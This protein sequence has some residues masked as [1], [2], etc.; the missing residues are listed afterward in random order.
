VF[1][2]MKQGEQV[3]MVPET[4]VQLIACIAE[5]GHFC[6]GATALDGAESL[7]YSEGSGPRLFDRLAHELAE[8]TI[9]ITSASAK[10]LYN[11]LQIGFEGQDLS[12]RLKPLSLLESLRVD[13]NLCSPDELV[14]SRVKIDESAGKCPK[15]GIQLRLINLDA[16]QKRRYREGL[17]HLTIA[18]YEDRYQKKDNSAEH[19]LKSFGQ[20]LENSID[21]PFTAIVDGPNVAFYMQNFQNGGFSY[22]QIQFVVDALEGMGE[23]VLVVLPKKYIHDRFWIQ[24][25]GGNDGTIMQRLSAKERMIR[26]SLIKSGKLYVVP[27]GNLD[28]FYWMFASVFMEESYV[29]ADNTEGRFAGIRPMLVSN[30]KLRDHRMSLLEPRLFRRWYSNFLVNFTF[31]AFVGEKCTSREIGF[32]TADIYSREIQCNDSECGIVWHFPV[33]DWNSTE[34]FCIRI[35]SGESCTK[36]DDHDLKA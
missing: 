5:N 1:A 35:P 22:H 20:W 30:D 3:E 17:L 31:S 4:F 29:P 21:D 9:E 25:L 7:G 24:R 12:K 6:E 27:G 14:A 13:N 11:A 16:D 19:N 33:G 34:C 15:T 18:R 26:D 10:R 28:D 36:S 8:N 23:K 32:R 2:K